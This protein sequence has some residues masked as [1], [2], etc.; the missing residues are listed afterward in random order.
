M[1]DEQ[2]VIFNS[3]CSTLHRFG[4]TGQF[5]LDFTFIAV[6]SECV[7]VSV[8]IRGR[9]T[10]RMANAKLIKLMFFL[11]LLSMLDAILWFIGT[12]HQIQNSN[13]MMNN[14]LK[15]IN[16]SRENPMNVNRTDDAVYHISRCKHANQNYFAIIHI[17]ANRVSRVCCVRADLLLAHDVII[18]AWVL[19]RDWSEP[20]GFH[21]IKFRSRVHLSRS[22]LHLPQD[23][24]PNATKMIEPLRWFIPELA[25]DWDTC[26]SGRS[27]K[28]DSKR[29]C[30]R[31]TSM[32]SLNL[33]FM[34]WLVI[35]SPNLSLT[36]MSNLFRVR[37]MILKWK[38]NDFV[39]G[40]DWITH[41]ISTLPLKQTL[42]WQTVCAKCVCVSRIVISGCLSRWRQLLQIFFIDFVHFKSH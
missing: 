33:I 19:V 30:S 40:P 7:C 42:Y 39:N 17:D 9:W 13:G 22:R 38:S 21:S 35:F 41:R 2:W 1:N 11:F 12:N 14:E 6:N 4:W 3:N 8:N 25:K 26:R 5:R 18:V 29:V 37:Q 31:S 10:K 28:S 16:F 23:L 15:S 34:R 36:P 20:Y 24:K 32:H 27:M